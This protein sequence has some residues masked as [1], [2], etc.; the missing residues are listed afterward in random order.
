VLGFQEGRFCGV[1]GNAPT[2]EEALVPSTVL[3]EKN[4]GFLKGEDRAPE[5]ESRPDTFLSATLGSRKPFRLRGQRT[6]SA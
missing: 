6:G 2:V 3:I 4:G 5:C 1:R